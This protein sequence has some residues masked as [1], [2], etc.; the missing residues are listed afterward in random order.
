MLHDSRCSLKKLILILNSQEECWFKKRMFCKYVMSTKEDRASFLETA[1]I[2][3]LFAGML[4]QQV[5]WVFET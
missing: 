2:V 5:C 1:S 4:S 3:F